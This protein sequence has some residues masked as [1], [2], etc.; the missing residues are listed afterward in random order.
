MVLLGGNS[1]KSID[2]MQ[3]AMGASVLRAQI[4]NNNIANA[5]TPHYKRHDLNFQAELERALNSEK[6]APGI[7]FKMSRERHIPSFRIKDYREVSPSIITDYNTYYNN[8]GNSVDIE[9]EM[10]EASKN[11]MYYIA[12]AQRTS[13]EFAK[14]KYLLR[15]TG[16]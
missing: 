2:L 14:L 9:K 3:R 7:P 5:T 13:K 8:D 4:L 15:T 12:L 1:T 6:E 11:T 10:I 16:A